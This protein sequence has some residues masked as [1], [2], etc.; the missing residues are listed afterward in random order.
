MTQAAA[1]DRNATAL[2]T[3]Y[4]EAGREQYIAALHYKRLNRTTYD[5]MRRGVHNGWLL[6]RRDTMPKTIAETILLCDKYHGEAARSS[7]AQPIRMP[8]VACVQQGLIEE[9]E[10][11]DKEPGVVT[12]QVEGGQDKVLMGKKGKPVRCFHCEGN[13][14]LSDCPTASEEEKKATAE[15][16]GVPLLGKWDGRMRK[17]VDEEKKAQVEGQAHLNVAVGDVEGQEWH[18]DDDV[19]GFS[20]LQMED[21]ELVDEQRRCETLNPSYFY[22]DSML[23]YNQV[24]EETNLENIRRQ[25]ISL[26][27]K[28]NGE[29]VWGHKKG[30]ALDLFRK[31]LVWQGIANLFLINILEHGGHRVT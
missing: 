13:H 16:K 1:N 5:E 30:D 15:R 6:H 10:E 28:C 3:K 29:E 20:F 4:R 27:G 22:L 11:Q 7:A 18:Q 17:P 31:W 21:E 24:F 12:A 9:N 2:L 19:D 14:F 23:S 26:C 8:G 25:A